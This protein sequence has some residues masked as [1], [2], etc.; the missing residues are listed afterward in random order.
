MLLSAPLDGLGFSQVSNLLSFCFPASNVVSIVSFLALI[1]LVDLHLW[2]GG[3]P[4]HNEIPLHPLGWLLVRKRKRKKKKQ[5]IN[6]GEDVEN[7]EPLYIAG[8]N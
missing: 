6:A 1:A 4:N 2:G 5:K 3:N 8:G 7:L